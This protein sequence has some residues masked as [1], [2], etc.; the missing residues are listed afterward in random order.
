[1]KFLGPALWLDYYDIHRIICAWYNT[2]CCIQQTWNQ[3]AK[4][5]SLHAPNYALKYTT[6]CTGLCTPSLLD[7]CSQD[8]PKYISKLLSSL[9]PTPF[10]GTLLASV[11][12]RPG[13]SYRPHANEGRAGPSVRNGPG[14][15]GFDFFRPGPQALEKARP[16]ALSAGRVMRHDCPKF[17][18]ER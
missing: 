17:V 14:R 12:E 11:H 18:T 13:R 1:M 10:C 6:D 7:L 9:L 5:T 2:L 16:A 15:A 8:T 4:C 3:T